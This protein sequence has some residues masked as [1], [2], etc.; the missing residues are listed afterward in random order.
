MSAQ[1]RIRRII[2]RGY[3][4]AFPPGEDPARDW[5]ATQAGGRGDLRIAHFGDC[6]HKTMDGPH[7]S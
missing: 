3:R 5:L 7:S 1:V 4:R 2:G 6:M